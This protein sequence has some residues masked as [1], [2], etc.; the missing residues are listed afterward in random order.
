V[1]NYRVSWAIGCALEV[2]PDGSIDVQIDDANCAGLVTREDARHLLNA[3]LRAHQEPPRRFC[4]DCR[5]SAVT[6]ARETIYDDGPG[7]ECRGCD[8]KGL[9]SDLRDA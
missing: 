9:T 4:P 3:L 7:S 6:P 5:S 1:P 2:L 8:W